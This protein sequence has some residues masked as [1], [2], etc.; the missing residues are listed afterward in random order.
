M[1]TITEEEVDKED[2]N[3]EGC[4]SGRTVSE[5][6]ESKQISGNQVAN[7]AV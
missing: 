6:G 4:R 3:W 2:E 7:E 5:N 1:R